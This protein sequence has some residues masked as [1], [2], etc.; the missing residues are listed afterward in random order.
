[1]L[2]TRDSGLLGAYILKG[3]RIATAEAVI[4]RERVARVRRAAIKAFDGDEDRAEDF[5]RSRQ[6]ELGGRPPLRAA[7]S[8]DDGAEAVLRILSQIRG[9]P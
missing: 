2:E 5:L 1:M 9:S 8:S 6:G 7:V 3:F 4:Q